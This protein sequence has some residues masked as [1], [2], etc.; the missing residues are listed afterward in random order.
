MPAVKIKN[1]LASCTQ[2]VSILYLVDILTILLLKMPAAPPRY[3]RPQ[4]NFFK[5]ASIVLD[6]FPE[7]LRHAFKTMWDSKHPAQPW[8][9]SVA[10]RN[11]LSAQE[12]HTPRIPTGKS[13]KEWDC[14]ALFQATIFSK[15]FKVY[16]PTKMKNVKLQDRYLMSSIP[17]KGSFRPTVTSSTGD[18]D[19]TFA[20]VI[21][22][23][24]LLRN[25]ILHSCTTNVLDK[26]K[27]DDCIKYAK[28]AFTVLHY[29]TSY[30][31]NTSELSESEFPTS[32]V[33]VL[34]E[35]IEEMRG[36]KKIFNCFVAITAVIV[37]ALL[38]LI[39]VILVTRLPSG[40]TAVKI[41]S[42][43]T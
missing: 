10:V 11:Q 31:D 35:R 5:F 41:N 32:N 29:S 2:C 4:L 12:G 34:K 16:C 26:N 40:K 8:D 30:I 17:P 36:D 13:Y 1:R 24:R 18:Q 3:E 28:I 37:I 38:L 27:F 43:K 22:Q 20:L 25:E 42:G 23:L 9:D 39:M 14:T 33:A 15:T 7:A 21:D 19:E 6:E